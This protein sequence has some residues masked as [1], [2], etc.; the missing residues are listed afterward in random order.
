[1]TRI[2]PLSKGT[3]DRLLK[4]ILGAAVMSLYPPDVDPEAIC[5]AVTNASKGRMDY[6]PLLAEKIGPLL[7][8]PPEE[9]ELQIGDLMLH[10]LTGQ[11]VRRGEAVRLTDREREILSLL[12]GGES[13]RQ[14]GERLH[15]SARSVAFHVSN[16]LTKLCLSSRVEAGLVAKGLEKRSRGSGGSQDL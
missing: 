5:Q 7:M 14:I 16:I 11:L 1:M 4:M 15:I 13:N 9:G 6:H 2:V 8:K 10:R 3:S 12:G